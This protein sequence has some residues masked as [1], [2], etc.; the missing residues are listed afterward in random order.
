MERFLA[1]VASSDYHDR[2]MRMLLDTFGIPLSS[3]AV[4]PVANARCVVVMNIRTFATH[5]LGICQRGLTRLVLDYELFFKVA[6]R[7]FRH[8]PGHSLI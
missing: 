1:M 3:T 8:L 4:R 6:H 5:D 2:Q 7:R